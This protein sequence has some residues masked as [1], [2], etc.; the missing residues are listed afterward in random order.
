MKTQI[1]KSAVLRP[2]GFA[3]RIDEIQCAEFIRS[4]W[5]EPK[6]LLT[7]RSDQLPRLKL[8][9]VWAGATC[10]A[11]VADLCKRRSYALHKFAD[12]KEVIGLVD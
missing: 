5:N 3:A 7:L 2:Y 12:A 9:E 1:E 8:D 4:A 11:R 10:C 6:K